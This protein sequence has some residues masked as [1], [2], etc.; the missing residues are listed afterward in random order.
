MTTTTADERRKMGET[1]SACKLCKITGGGDVVRGTTTHSVGYYHNYSSSGA[2]RC[3]DLRKFP[4]HT[5]STDEHVDRDEED[6]PDIT[7]KAPAIYFP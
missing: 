2:I 6:P 4:A 1:V 3:S 5:P 7:F